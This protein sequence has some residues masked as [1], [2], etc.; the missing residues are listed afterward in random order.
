M[1]LTKF[2][3]PTGQTG[4]ILNISD[5]TKMVLGGVVLLSSLSLAQRL[6]GMLGGRTAGLIDTTPNAFTD[7]RP[8]PPKD[9]SRYL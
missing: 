4:D 1:K 9:G 3:T 5:W 8:E 6:G 2:Q 7:A